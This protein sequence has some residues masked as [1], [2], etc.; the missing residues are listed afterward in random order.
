M[1]GKQA[2]HTQKQQRMTPAMLQKGINVSLSPFFL[3][4]GWFLWVIYIYSRLHVGS[5]LGDNR[6]RLVVAEG[7][8][9]PLW[10]IR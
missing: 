2:R 9:N 3:P 5:S 10:P 1:Q 8:V 7:A 6:L 4:V